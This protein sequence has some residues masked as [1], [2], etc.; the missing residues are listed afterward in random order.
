[1]TPAD[2][3]LLALAEKAAKTEG[4]WADY[5]FSAFGDE[6]CAWF[7]ACSPERIKDLLRRLGEAEKRAASAAA[8]ED[9]ALRKVQTEAYKL[10]ALCKD[11]REL[12]VGG[13]DP[14]GPQADSLRTAMERQIIA[15]A[16]AADAAHQHHKEKP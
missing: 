10:A 14:N 9:D 8:A 7:V 3:E 15:V 2:A 16:R 4:D 6:V 1:M 11:M 5:E 12:R 13:A